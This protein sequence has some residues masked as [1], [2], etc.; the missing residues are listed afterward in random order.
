MEAGN[1]AGAAADTGGPSR[2]TTRHPQQQ[3]KE[4]AQHHARG[5][6]RQRD[7]NEH[8]RNGRRAR[9]EAKRQR[10][11]AERPPADHH[12]QQQGQRAS[13][14]TVGRWTTAS[15]AEAFSAKSMR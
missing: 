15:P 13:K 5:D 11:A 14:R 10:P 4:Q 2:P 1:W 3:T 12:G 6:R 9:H 7:R 8:G